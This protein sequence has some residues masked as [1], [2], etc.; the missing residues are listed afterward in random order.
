VVR[1]DV[2]HIA[3]VAVLGHLRLVVQK[4]LLKYGAAADLEQ[5]I[6][7]LDVA[8][9]LV[10]VLLLADIMAGKQLDDKT[11]NLTQVVHTP[12]V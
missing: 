5:V 2:D 7:V 9:I 6:A 10:L 12:S 1:I 11:D 8:A 4:L 3:A